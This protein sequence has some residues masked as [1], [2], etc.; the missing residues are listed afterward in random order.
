VRQLHAGQRN[1]ELRRLRE[2]CLVDA[3]GPVLYSL[4]RHVTW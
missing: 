2:H 1:R 4:M 3:R